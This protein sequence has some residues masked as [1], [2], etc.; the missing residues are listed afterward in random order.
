LRK[1]G[2]KAAKVSPKTTQTISSFFLSTFMNIFYN[3]KTVINIT[4]SS[5]RSAFYLSPVTYNLGHS[6]INCSK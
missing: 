5:F 4:A 3:E 6:F 1:A 2:E